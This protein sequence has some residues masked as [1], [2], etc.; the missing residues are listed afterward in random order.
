MSLKKTLTIAG[1]DTSGGAGIQA[2][3]KTFQEHGTYGMTAV[4]VVV[5][6]DPDQNWSHNVYSLPIDVVKAQLKTALS[7]GVDAIKTGM[8]STEEVIQTAGQAIDESGLDH[9]VIDPVMVCKGEDEV[10]NPGNTD[11]M[12]TYLLPKAEIVTPNLFE[13]GQ[14]ASMKTPK[15]IEDMKVAAQKIHELGARNVVIKG[16]KQLDHEEAVDLFYDGLTY[17]L[18]KSKR[19]DTYHNHGAGCTFAAAITANLAN[20]LSI[21]DAVIQAKQFVTAAIAHGWKLNEY[22]GPVMHGAKNQFDVPQVE[23]QE[24]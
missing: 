13:A 5:T 21:K 11:A 16:G 4:T 9:V 12:I 6:M 17:T 20:G 14:L 19:S 24:V 10:L 18:L 2:D 3:L 23:L 15:T 8:L 1:S 7:T 22:V